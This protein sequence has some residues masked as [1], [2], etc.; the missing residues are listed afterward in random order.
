MDPWVKRIDAI[1]LFVEDLAAAK[2]FY[3]EVFALPVHYEDPNSTVFKFGE[4]VVNLLDVRQA[5]EL[6]AP[7]NVASPDAGSRMVFT[8]G[9]DDVDATC[10]TLRAEGS[11]AAQWTDGPAV[12]HPDGQ[13]PRPGRL[14]L[15]D[16]DVASRSARPGHQPLAVEHRRHDPPAERVGDQQRRRRGRARGRASAWITSNAMSEVTSDQREARRGG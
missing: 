11:G 16:R 9:V 1:T 3:L 4:T 2:A 13:L 14:H 8:I 5:N 7:A 15:G 10:D 6:V 12:G